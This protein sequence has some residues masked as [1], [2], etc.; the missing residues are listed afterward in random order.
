MYFARTLYSGI[1]EKDPTLPTLTTPKIMVAN[2]VM[3]VVS[4]GSGGKNSVR[5]L[6]TRAY[7]VA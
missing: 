1:T 7:I 3:G 6:Y 5:L 2:R 4:V